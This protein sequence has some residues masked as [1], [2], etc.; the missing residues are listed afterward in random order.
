M[1]TLTRAADLQAELAEPDAAARLDVTRGWILCADGKVAEAAELVSVVLAAPGLSAAGR[2]N[3]LALLAR[4]RADDTPAD[5]VIFEQAHAAYVEARDHEGAASMAQTLAWL[6]SVSTASV[7]SD[8]LERAQLQTPASSTRGQASLARTR[9]MAATV[10]CEWKECADN[11][12]L[13]LALARSLGSV[14]LQIWSLTTLS[15]ARMELGQLD[16]GS[17]HCAELDLL[18]VGARPRQRLN[19][20][21]SSLP[22]LVRRGDASAARAA[23]TEMEDLLEQCGP[24]ARASIAQVDGMLAADRGDYAAALAPWEA[25]EK[26]SLAIGWV[27]HAAQSRLGRLTALYRLDEPSAV[28]ALLELAALYD[29]EQAPAAARLARAVAGCPEPGD[30]ATAA[31]AAWTAE[32]AARN[33]RTQWVK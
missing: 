28:P 22:L 25:A 26:E 23:R 1:A 15:E 18:T 20:L 3:A 16:S 32:H 10:R 24:A 12:E 13:A 5:L 21:R 14:D 29:D 8:W 31:E 2:A 19:A 7:F 27:L 17:E 11:A 6:L 9:A 4:T 33:A 30:P